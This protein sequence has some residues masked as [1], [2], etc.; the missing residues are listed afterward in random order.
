[1]PNGDGSVSPD[2]RRPRRFSPAARHLA[3]LVL[4]Y[5]ALALGIAVLQRAYPGV[6][7]PIT[8]VPQGLV[9]ARGILRAI[10]VMLGALALALPLAWVFVITRRR[11]GFSQSIVHTLIILPIAVAGIMVVVQNSLALAF[12]LAGIAALRFRNTLEDTKDAIY[13]FVATGIGIAAAADQF[14]VGLALSFLFNAT[15]IVLWWT[16]YGRTPAQLKAKLMLRRLRQTR[17]T[18]IPGAAAPVT[19]PLNAI[20]RVHVVNPDAAQSSVAAVLAQASKQWELTGVSP[21]TNGFS[22]LDYV[23]RL[24]AK[25]ARGALLNELRANGRPDV[26]G[27][28]FR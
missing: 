11:K 6:T 23:V 7:S 25:T 19:D 16:N 13:L 18:R 8:G 4:Y 21:G 24:R 22:T 5:V 3:L 27:A 28:E 1:M 26:V 9:T 12:G 15:I 10:T 14:G 20:L 2:G 17:V